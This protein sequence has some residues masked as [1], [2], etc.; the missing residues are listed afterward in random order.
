MLLGSGIGTAYFGREKIRQQPG[1]APHTPPSQLQQHHR[2][3]GGRS[4]GGSSSSGGRRRNNDSG[5]RG[6]KV[7]RPSLGHQDASLLSMARVSPCAA[8]KGS[9]WGSRISWSLPTCERE[10]DSLLPV[11]ACYHA[12]KGEAF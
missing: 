1:V 5:G 11:R 3:G 9:R 10:V 2:G 12:G 7:L 4:G 6:L 8:V